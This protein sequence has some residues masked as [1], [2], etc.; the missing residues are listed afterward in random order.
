MKSAP[1]LV[2][3][4]AAVAVLAAGQAQAEDLLEVYRPALANDPQ[5]READALRRAAREQRPQAWAQVLPQITGAASIQRDDEESSGSFPTLTLS[6]PA[7]PTSPL[8]LQVFPRDSKT[9]PDIDTWSLDLRQSIFSWENWVALRRA[10]HQVAQAEAD[11]G[12]AQ[13]DLMLRVAQRYFDVLGA[14]DD[15]EAEQAALEAISRQL[16]QAEKRFEVGLIAITDV[17][18]TRAARDNA[19]AAVIEAKRRLATAEELLREVTGAKYDQLAKPDA[20]IPLKAPEP[21]DEDRWVEASL[22]QNLRLI[23]SRLGA[24]IARENVRASY[25]GHLPS[26]ELFATRS[27]LEVE[28]DQTFAPIPERGF[29]GGT[30]PATQEEDTTTYGL[31]FSVPI[32]SG[33]LAQ[34]RVRESQFRWI[35]ARE[36]FVRTSRE[37][38]REARDAYLGVI[39]E[40]AR[41]NALRQALESSQT[42]LKA[43]EAGYEVGTRTSVDV[44]DARRTLVAAQSNFARSRYSYI[45]NV[46]RLRAAAG[47]LNEETLAEVNAWLNAT[48]QLSTPAGAPQP[49]Q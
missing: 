47:T 3:L 44:L 26:I 9:K 25:G 28:A 37:T 31:R 29:A 13:Q 27:H 4:V 38:E 12:V 14:R 46:L 1:S 34:S 48:A 35:A 39:S 7:D 10:G 49:Q 30:A 17:Q 19:A 40:I 42:A 18:D 41:V 8:V 11:Y 20:N 22:N 32:F 43:T 15:L 23:S 24:D 2:L 21:A 6:N 5:I 45:M 36:R 16:E 33:G